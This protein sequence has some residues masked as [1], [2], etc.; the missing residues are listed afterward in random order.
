MISDNIGIMNSFLPDELSQNLIENINEFEK[1]D[2]LK[3]AKIGSEVSSNT[4]IRKDSIYWLD[5][6]N[7]NDH[8]DKFLEI[9]RGFIAY[10][11]MSCYAGITDCEFHYSL[12]EKGDFYSKHLDQFKN[13]NGRKYSMISYLNN[14]WVEADA[15]ELLIHH[16][17]DTQL[18]SP[19]TGKTVIF[20]SDKVVHEVL[21]T[22]SRRMSVTGWL[23]S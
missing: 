21:T 18:I 7:H 10:L 12:Y 1:K 20:K 4:K 6:S 14:D 13:N 8:E 15:G 3:S 16:K 9:I 19:N 23:K 11:N 22:N 17:T 2:L 5:A